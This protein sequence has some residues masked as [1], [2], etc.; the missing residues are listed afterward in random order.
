[1]LKLVLDSTAFLTSMVL[2]EGELYTTPEV[3]EEIK[4]LEGRL[5]L[6]TAKIKVL[7]VEPVKT[8]ARLSRTDCTLLALAKKLDATLVTDDYT[9]QNE[10]ALSNIKFLSLGKRGITHTRKHN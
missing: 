5:R 10:A 4:S 3:V 9:L 6:E 2:P 1:M 8:R 7:P